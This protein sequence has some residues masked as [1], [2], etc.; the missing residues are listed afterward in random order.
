[1]RWTLAMTLGCGLGLVAAGC[2]SD[3]NDPKSDPGAPISTDNTKVKPPPQSDFNKT[4]GNDPKASPGGGG[5][6]ATPKGGGDGPPPEIRKGM[7]SGSYKN[8][9]GSQGP[10]EPAKGKDA[11]KKDDAKTGDDKKGDEPKKDDAKKD[12]V[13]LSDDEIANIKKLPADDQK[14]AMEQ[15]V[16]PVGEDEGKPNHLGGMGV[17]VKETVNGKVAFLCCKSCE[18]DFKKD[19]DKYLAKIGK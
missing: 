4:L 11:E 18:G 14:I 5:G 6:S 12:Q 9:P 2:G 7:E 16:C 3:T 1:M 17:P 13:T 19:P 15:K 8:M 10:G